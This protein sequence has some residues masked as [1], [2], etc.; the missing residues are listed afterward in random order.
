[1]EEVAGETIT[2]QVLGPSRTLVGTL[3]AAGASPCALQTPERSEAVTEE[4]DA[5][6][7][8]VRI[9][10]GER[11]LRTRSPLNGHEGGNAGYGQ[12]VT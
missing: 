3:P 11:G 7:P 2:A 4:P 8:H 10:G 5:G 9:R 1:M 6:K 12:A